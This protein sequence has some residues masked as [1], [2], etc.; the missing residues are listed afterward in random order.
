MF[1]CEITP[2]AVIGARAAASGGAMEQLSTRSLPTGA[3]VPSL[4]T[5]NILQREVV[6][7]A[8]G[9]VLEAIGAQ[10]HEVSAIIP[11]AACHIILLDFD[12]LPERKEEARAIVR[13][14]LKKA[15]PFD[16][17]KA[18][19]SYDVVRDKSGVKVVAAVMLDSV[20]NDY[21]SLFRE[22]GC[23]PGVVLPST[24]SALALIDAPEP[25]MALKVDPLS[26]S[27]AIVQA[28]QLLLYRTLEHTGKSTLTAGQLADD[29]YPSVVYFAD[30][31]KLNIQ[32][33]VIA[34]LPDFARIAPSLEQQT[35][36]A[37]HEMIPLGIPGETQ[38]KSELSGVAGALLG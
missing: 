27:L 4:L 12:A 26:S 9:K 21:E 28:N 34:G 13:F 37:V 30:N 11:D 17:E 14:R 7:E 8:L 15:L 3:L 16:A 6:K 1:A 31:F 25:T 5:E 20:L 23:S 19:I 24:T 18:V 33:L 10:G 36:L 22:L 32:R 29:I 2:T 35:G 38:N